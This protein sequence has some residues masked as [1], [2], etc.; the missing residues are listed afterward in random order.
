[1]GEIGY[2][3]NLIF[4]YPIFNG[5]VLLYHLFGDFALS[6]IV[7]TL[8][9]KLLLFPLTLKQLKSMKATQ[10]LQPQMQEIKKKYGKDQQGQAVA[11]QALYKEYG[12][13]PL[14]GCLP[15]LVQLPVLYGM[16]YAFR[17]FLGTSKVSDLN[18]IVYPFVPHFTNYPNI[19]LNWFTFINH[20]WTISLAHPD[21]THILPIIAGLAT[22]IQL[23]M[24][25]PKTAPGATPD[26]STQSMK[27]MQYVMPLVT[28]FFGWTFPAGLALYWTVSTTFQAVQQFFVTG[29]GSL[30]TTPDFK[31]AP[32]TAG[33]SNGTVATTPAPRKERAR[34]VPTVVEADND[35]LSESDENNEN[36]ASD[37][38]LERRPRPDGTPY[39][40]RR[41]RSNSASARRR[42]SAQRSRG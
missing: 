5:L 21:P 22:F 2:L 8:I 31:M 29:W 42:S 16:Y 38:A 41:Q 36:N 3:F 6:I 28:L 18:N 12:V 17:T 35:D 26:P 30:L 32:A 20:S 4:T 37:G 25:Q 39:N 7:L 9:I 15:L 13:N 27:M 11:M 10:A 23:R 1:M 34:V 19:Y 14:S 40:R 24:S 33:K